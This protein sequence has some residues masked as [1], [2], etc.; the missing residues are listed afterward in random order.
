MKTWFITG[1]SRGLGLETARAALAAGDQVVATGR[2][3]ATITAALGAS[4]RLLTAT[5]D[6]TDAKSIDA[7]V[8]A[9]LARF[10]R[11]DVL[12]NNAG[13][14]LLGAFEELSETSVRR[15]FDTNVFGALAVARAVLPVMRQQRSGHMIS[16]ASLAGIVGIEM[17]SIYCATKFALAGW[18]E[19]L[20]AELAGFGIHATVV[21]PGRFRTD[22]LDP[23]SVTHADLSI[24]DY[25]AG[26][27]D[28][29]KALAAANHQQ[30]G[31]PVAFGQLMVDL[32]HTENP[33]IRL[34]A[35][36]DAVE[37]MDKKAESLQA[38]TDEWRQK[39]I[40]T[41]YAD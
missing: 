32:A 31:D 26:A 38:T 6:V 10:G 33:P 36:T 23:S 27:A 11:I 1:A 2:N 24:D 18:S 7:A 40:A 12:V 9:T 41:D 8:D 13:Y 22:F 39:S 19:S 21:C 34:A 25:A 15:Q 29:K 35:G 5:L 37:V 28:R 14:G 20:S 17:S 30:M 3:P 16:I 4:E